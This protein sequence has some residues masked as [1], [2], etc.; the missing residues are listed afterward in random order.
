M[1]LYTI[2]ATLTA[3]FFFLLVILPIDYLKD[4]YLFLCPKNGAPVFSDS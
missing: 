2:D 4:P 3:G 1:V